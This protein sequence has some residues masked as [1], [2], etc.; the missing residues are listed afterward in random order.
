MQKDTTFV[1]CNVNS[2]SI[3]D[4]NGKYE[5][6]NSDE[7][8]DTIMFPLYNYHGKC[9][10]DIVHTVSI[11]HTDMDVVLKG[12]DGNLLVVVRKAGWEITEI[13]V[14]P[15]ALDKVFT[16]YVF[17]SLLFILSRNANID[18]D[19]ALLDDLYKWIIGVVF[20]YSE[21]KFER[22]GDTMSFHSLLSLV[23][24]NDDVSRGI[25]IC[26]VELN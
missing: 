9:F 21:V 18:D 10:K 20:K 26:G 1:A 2:F 22:G 15:S 14:C 25:L 12:V 13:C 23:V 4:E 24:R 3:A 11:L 5:K 19:E 7:L 8:F 17:S 6:F 16:S